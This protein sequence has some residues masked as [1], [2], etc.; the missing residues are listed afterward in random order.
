[1]S[2]PS[3]MVVVGYLVRA[4]LCG[5]RER[6]AEHLEHL[7]S[8]REAA[9]PYYLA[10]RELLDGFSRDAATFCAQRPAKGKH[11]GTEARK[12]ACRSPHRFRSELAAAERR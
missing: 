4:L 8:Y 2:R 1:M 10:M 7:K 5:E 11:K 3:L 9:D 6:A 12:S